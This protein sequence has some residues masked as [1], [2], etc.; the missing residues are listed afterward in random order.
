MGQSIGAVEEERLVGR[1]ADEAKC[2]RRKQIVG[3]MFA[4]HG[5]ASQFKAC[6]VVIEILGIV[7]MGMI[8]IEVAEPAVETLV[9]GASFSSRIAEG[10]LTNSAATITYV[11]QYFCD[12]DVLV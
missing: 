1:V 6:V 12:R 4:G 5:V 7:V 3:V 9:G 10:P 11:F 2:P 8:L